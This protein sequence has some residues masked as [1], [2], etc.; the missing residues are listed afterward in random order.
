MK[1]VLFVH[2]INGGN[3]SHFRSSLSRFACFASG[4]LLAVTVAGANASPITP[5][6]VEQFFARY[7]ATGRSNVEMQYNL[8][9]AMG[10]AE[11]RRND[12]HVYMGMVWMQEFPSTLKLENDFMRE[13]ARRWFFIHESEHALILPHLDPIEPSENAPIEVWTQFRLMQQV[14]E[15]AADALALIKMWKK[16]GKDA[17]LPIANAIIPF[18]TQYGGVT[19]QTQCAL[20]RAVATLGEQ[21][22]RITS[23][24]DVLLYAFEIA[25]RCA[26]ETALRL[27]TDNVGD[28]RAM[29][30]MQSPEVVQTIAQIH[31][32]LALVRKDNAS[33]R[34]ANNAGTTRFANEYGKSSPRDYHFYVGTD[35]TITRD[36]VLGAE[37]ARGKVALTTA[38]SATTTEVQVLAV[39]AVKKVRVVSLDRLSDT[40]K[41][42]VRFVNVFAGNSTERRMR[43]FAIIESVITEIDPR[44][45]LGA[46]YTEVNRRLMFDLGYPE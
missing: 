21:P 40:E 43:A 46:L 1:V 36:A 26:Y 6:E 14:H 3:M 17:A 41:L 29:A 10:T 28:K 11:S 34:F 19:H 23:D 13:L 8:T 42:F 32:G 27:L 15:N 25:E 30:I 44:E 22:E 39:A 33:G 24:N 2:F 31:L 18:R 16:D 20:E 45:P 7:M 5:A 12:S 37:G 4:I 35:N 9:V 38:M